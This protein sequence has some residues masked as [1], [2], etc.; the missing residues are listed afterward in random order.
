MFGQFVP[1]AKKF[2]LAL[3]SKGRTHSKSIFPYA[4]FLSEASEMPKTQKGFLQQAAASKNSLEDAQKINST[5]R[6]N[7]FLFRNQVRLRLLSRQDQ[8]QTNQN[9]YTQNRHKHPIVAPPVKNYFLHQS[10]S[11]VLRQIFFCSC[12]K[13]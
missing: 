8:Y 2:I 11:M 13:P 5:Q 6:F 4:N 10:S 9:E 1:Y 12:R 3:F 7:G